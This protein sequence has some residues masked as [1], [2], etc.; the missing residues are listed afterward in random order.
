M[1][2]ISYSVGDYDEN[3]CVDFSYGILQTC[4][5]VQTAHKYMEIVV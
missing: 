5:A 1:L 4:S 2:I 3:S